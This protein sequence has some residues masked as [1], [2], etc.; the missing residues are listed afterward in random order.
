MASQTD[1]RGDWYIDD[2][3][4]EQQYTT[5]EGSKLEKL[6]MSWLPPDVHKRLEDKYEEANLAKLTL[7]VS[8]RRCIMLC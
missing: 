1:L 6:S 8:F 3:L 7:E 2:S 4:D 5:Y